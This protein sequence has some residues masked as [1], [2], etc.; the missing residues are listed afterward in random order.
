MNRPPRNRHAAASRRLGMVAAL[1]L[2]AL[3]AV[4]AGCG[5]QSEG[6]PA[7]SIHIETGRTKAADVD[8]LKA[9]AKP[10]RGRRP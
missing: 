9:Q 6:R 3:L 5:P 2:A 10:A 7:G 1:G 8:A 4:P